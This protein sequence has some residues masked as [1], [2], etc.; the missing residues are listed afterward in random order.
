MSSQEPQNGPRC[1]FRNKKRFDVR[2][3]VAGPTV[4]ICDECI[5]ICNDI[6]ADDTAP[7]AGGAALVEAAFLG[8]SLTGGLV[9]CRLCQVLFSRDE[10]VAFPDRGWL[11]HG[12]V[13]MVRQQPALQRDPPS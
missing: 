13:E 2:T 11:C 3:L 1:S 6:M 7:E 4:Y 8:K 12:C 10:C 5:D 9:R